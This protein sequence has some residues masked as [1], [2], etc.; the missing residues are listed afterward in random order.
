M[1]S[2]INVNMTPEIMTR[3]YNALRLWWNEYS[4]VM[5]WDEKVGKLVAKGQRP[6]DLE[7]AARKRAQE[8]RERLLNAPIDGEEMERVRQKLIEAF[9]A[10]LADSVKRNIATFGPEC[11]ARFDRVG[12]DVWEWDYRPSPGVLRRQTFRGP[13]LE[14][15]RDRHNPLKATFKGT[16][17][18]ALRKKETGY[19]IVFYYWKLEDR[20]FEQPKR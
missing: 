18:D 15:Q 14:K 3:E 17:Y 9:E 12:D 6:Q 4:E 19:D 2:L 13:H 8:D 11:G 16:Y 1:Q 5:Y 20:W 7:A 10:S